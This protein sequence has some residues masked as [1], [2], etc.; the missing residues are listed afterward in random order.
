M[1]RADRTRL[2]FLTSTHV[3]DDLYQGA[4]PALLPFLA[5][6]RH[7]SYAGLTGITLAA[8]FLAS[9]VQPGFGALTDR[10][11]N[12]GWLVAV[13]LLVAGLGIGV[14]GLARPGTARSGTARPGGSRSS[15]GSSVVRADDWRGFGRL[16]VMVVLRSI[17]YF[18]LASLLALYAIRHFHASAAVGS[19]VL[20]V[21]IGSGVIGTLGG[22]WLADHWQRVGVL[23]LGYGLTGLAVVLLVAAPD[24]PMLFIVAF[25]LGIVLF[26]PFAVQVT[27]GQDF[28]PNRIGTAS[29]VTLG[30]AVS[31]GGI[32]APLF[33]LLADTYGLT[34][35]LGTIAA[36]PLVACLLTFFLRDPRARLAVAATVARTGREPGPVR[37]G[38]EPVVSAEAPGEVVLV[39]PSDGPA[40]TG[41][42]LIGP[43]EQVRGVLGAQPGQIRH[44]RQ[45]GGGLEQAHQVPGGQVQL[46]GQLSQGPVLGQPGFQQAHG[47]PDGGADRLGRI[48]LQPGHGGD[49]PAE[50]AEQER[51]PP[52]DVPSVPRHGG[53][54]Q[55][56]ERRQVNPAF[57]EGAW[58]GV[59]RHHA[60][61]VGRVGTGPQQV[62]EHRIFP[63][64][65][66]FTA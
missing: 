56:R 38:G 54:A 9:V 29:G 14:S 19:A 31:A 40:D 60:V 55:R 11:R 61:A 64:P 62:A 52:D 36:F 32:A 17:A 47:V 28:L 34:T 30:L 66:Q 18:G 2:A 16:T 23:R 57:L 13:G 8:T 7:Y 20:T 42:R 33:G 5:I 25:A 45:A 65:G 41:D 53:V 59:D 12:L 37:A 26:A 22:G 63:G 43:Q 50:D 21:F 39:R 24:V 6:E 1:T 58:I 46:L 35:A 49:R 10:Y 48:W 4:V 15:A 44:G 27:L 51:Q 3:V